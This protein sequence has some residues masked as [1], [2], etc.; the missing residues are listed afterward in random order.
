MLFYYY[1][2]SLLYFFLFNNNIIIT[3]VD[4]K[5]IYHFYLKYN[6]SD[7]PRPLQTVVAVFVDICK[8]INKYYCDK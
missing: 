3:I 6:S 1:Y 7:P 8:G 2:W 4:D 5:N